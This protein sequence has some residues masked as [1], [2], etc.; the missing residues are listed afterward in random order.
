MNAELERVNRTI[1]SFASRIEAETRK[2]RDDAQAKREKREGRIQNAKE[3]MDS[4]HV[5][6]KELEDAPKVGKT[7]V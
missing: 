3:A 1:Q 4:E 5:R 7:P 6:L 2:L